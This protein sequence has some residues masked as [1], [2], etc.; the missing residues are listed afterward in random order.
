MINGSGLLLVPF[1]NDKAIH[2]QNSYDLTHSP[3][4]SLKAGN[5]QT[6]VWSHH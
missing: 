4:E 3:D 2:M 6:K 5:F 1:R